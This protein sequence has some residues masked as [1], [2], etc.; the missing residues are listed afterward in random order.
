[1]IDSR[2]YKTALKFAVVL[3]FTY[4]QAVQAQPIETI[5]SKDGPRVGLYFGPTWA[6]DMIHWDCRPS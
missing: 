2:I 1:M 6:M 3:S 4:V 5:I